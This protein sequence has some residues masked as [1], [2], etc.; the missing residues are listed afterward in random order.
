MIRWIDNRSD[1]ITAACE[2]GDA[3]GIRLHPVAL[4]HF[5]D[6]S[7]EYRLPFPRLERHEGYLFGVVWIPSNT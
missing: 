3:L 7:L 4:R 6:S 1:R 5:A 2:A